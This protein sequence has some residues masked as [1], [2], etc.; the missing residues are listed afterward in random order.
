MHFERVSSCE[1]SCVDHIIISL[2]YVLSVSPTMLIIDLYFIV[3]MKSPYVFSSTMRHL[4]K[5]ETRKK[6]H[7][8]GTARYKCGMGPEATRFLNRVAEKLVATTREN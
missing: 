7:L 4:D 2:G 8:Q 1:S 6:R 3:F 5:G